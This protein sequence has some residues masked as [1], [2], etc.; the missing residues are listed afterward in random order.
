[1]GEGGRRVIREYVSV[2]PDRIGVVIGDRGTIKSRIEES[3]GV[4]LTVD[5][6]S[7]SV[8]LEIDPDKTPY[9]NMMKA[10]NIITAIG[11]GFSPEK[12]FKLLEDDV[13]LDVIDLTIYVGTSKNHLTR[14]KGRIIGENGKTRKII[15]EYTGTFVSVYSNYVAIIGT[16]ENVSVARRAVEMLASGKPHNAVYS[17]LDREKRRLKKLEFEL[18]EKRKF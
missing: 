17:F 11:Y 6:S 16:Y 7:S 13:I 2:P 14:I 12:A 5:S 8:M 15:E 4:A 9:E 18:W 1:M 10:K 3:T